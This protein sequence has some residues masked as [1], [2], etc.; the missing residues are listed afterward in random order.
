MVCFGCLLSSHWAVVEVICVG[1]KTELS[2]VQS[3]GSG[4]TDQWHLVV[5]R[6]L[7]SMSMSINAW[8]EGL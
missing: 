4:S 3:E 2:A 5:D 1:V 6:L 7:D 8:I